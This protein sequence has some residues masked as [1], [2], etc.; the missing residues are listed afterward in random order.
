MHDPDIIILDEHLEYLDNLKVSGETNVFV[1]RIHLK[2][3]YPKLTREEARE[4]VIYWI[5]T[6]SERQQNE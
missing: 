2:E 3:A 5:E 1:F 4:I 6:F